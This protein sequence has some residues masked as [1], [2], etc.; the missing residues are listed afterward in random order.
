MATETRSNLKW[1]SSA[2]SE[3]PHRAPAR[4]MLRAVGLDDEDMSKPF[5]AIGNLASD[6]TPCNVHLT[7]LADKVKEGVWAANA[8]P[9]MFGTITVSDGIS[10]APRA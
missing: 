3:G 7:R 4:A 8:V 1:Q 2:V 9:F 6:V 10:M 5:V